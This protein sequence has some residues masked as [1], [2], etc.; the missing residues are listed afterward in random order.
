VIADGTL[1][2]AG[3]VIAF[4]SI[5][6]YN[7]DPSVL[8]AWAFHRQTEMTCDNAMKMGDWLMV[9]I[10]PER[11]FKIEEECR[12]LEKDPNAG[13]A[14]AILLRQTYRQQEMIQ[15]AVNEIARL[16][17]VLMDL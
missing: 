2:F 8:A 7:L 12:A 15:A 3:D 1:A 11:L 14:A 13:K 6:F 9:D 10:P 17:L 16:E 4:A 5:G